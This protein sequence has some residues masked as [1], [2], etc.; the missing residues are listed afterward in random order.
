MGWNAH[1]IE[2]APL[3]KVAVIIHEINAGYYTPD[4][5]HECDISQP[6]TDEKRPAL[7]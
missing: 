7:L 4:L 6:K 3:R 2:H 5:A 1:E